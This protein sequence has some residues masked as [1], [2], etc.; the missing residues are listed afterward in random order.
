MQLECGRPSLLGSDVEQAPDIVH[1]TGRESAT[2]VWQALA[3]IQGQISEL[4][5][6]RTLKGRSTS[7]FL[8]QV[9][10]LDA[11]LLSFDASLPPDLRFKEG[12]A[13]S[14]GVTAHVAMQHHVAY[15]ALH[16]AALVAP[17]SFYR[18]AVERHCNTGLYKDRLSRGESICSASAQAVARM[19]IELTEQSAYTSCLSADAPMLACTALAVLVL[20]GSSKLLRATNYEVCFCYTHDCARLTRMPAA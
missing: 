8:H 13:G 7:D 5:Y 9:G 11:K 16:R 2:I 18:G 6:K 20:K 1:A 19:T 12:D 10:S 15:L 4:I 3:D 14:S 17:A